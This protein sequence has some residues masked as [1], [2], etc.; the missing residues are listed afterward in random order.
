MG[1]QVSAESKLSSDKMT[2]ADFAVYRPNVRK[3]DASKYGKSGGTRAVGPVEGKEGELNQWPKAKL[4]AIQ[5]ISA[6]N[7]PWSSEGAAILGKLV[8][9]T[10]IRRTNAQQT[11]DVKR[12]ATD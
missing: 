8:T 10:A 7:R 4:R 9:T 3:T 2:K 12:I 6:P 1:I 5:P 11:I